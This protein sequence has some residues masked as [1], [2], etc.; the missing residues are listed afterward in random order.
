MPKCLN[1]PGYAA[2]FAVIFYALIVVSSVYHENKVESDLVEFDLEHIESPLSE[3][4]QTERNRL[5]GKIIHDTGR[6]FAPISGAIGAILYFLLI[7]V[8]IIVITR[9]MAAATKQ[10]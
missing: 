10:Q 4:D 9:L 1:L 3:E 7:W 8:V 5:F 6:T 2:I